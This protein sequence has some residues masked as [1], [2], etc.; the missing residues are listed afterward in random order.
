MNG[1]P[2]PAHGLVYVC[3]STGLGLADENMLVLF[4]ADHPLQ[5]V[6]RRVVHLH[7]AQGLQRK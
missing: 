7:S 4:V 5:L 3:V 1:Q 6:A 2:P